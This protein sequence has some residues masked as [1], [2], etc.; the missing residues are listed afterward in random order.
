LRFLLVVGL[1][2]IDGNLCGPPPILDGFAT[3]LILM[4]LSI[5][6]YLAG[7]KFFEGVAEADLRALALQ[8]QFLMLQGGVCIVEH[9]QLNGRAY[10]LVEG[11]V[12]TVVHAM[13]GK[14]VQLRSS[15]DS[16]FGIYSIYKQ[17]SPISVETVRQSTIIAIRGVA[18]A[19]FMADHPTLYPRVLAHM[20]GQIKDVIEQ[21]VEVSTLG[22]RSRLSSEL[23]RMCREESRT[24]DLAILSPAPTHAELAR[25]INTN[26]ET[27][28]RELSRLQHNRVVLRQGNRLVVPSIGLLEK[29]TAAPP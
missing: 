16:I 2:N 8:A 11:E 28:S 18:F 12:R 27:V 26:R 29:L 23:L 14:A 13:N 19:R 9:G 5:D 6:K 10:F 17:P 21:F 1:Q 3:D 7:M 20:G 4:E 15:S 22:V 24:E 25:R